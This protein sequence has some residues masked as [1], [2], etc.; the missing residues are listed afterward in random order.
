MNIS[1]QYL[2]KMLN[3]KILKTVPKDLKV[4]KIKNNRLSYTSR[5]EFQEY[6]RNCMDFEL[7]F[8]IHNNDKVLFDYANTKIFP[9][10]IDN[11]SALFLTDIN[12]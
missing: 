3:Y 7:F 11:T 10:E 2:S 12:Q 1:R 9:I 6:I 4:N 8:K 5:E